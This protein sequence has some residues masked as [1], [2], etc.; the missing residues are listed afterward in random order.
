MR[1]PDS[2]NLGVSDA[3]S[4]LERM[5]NI[6]SVSIDLSKSIAAWFVVLRDVGVPI[7]KFAFGLPG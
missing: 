5:K 3:V 2:T 7:Y 6:I 1:P 4:K